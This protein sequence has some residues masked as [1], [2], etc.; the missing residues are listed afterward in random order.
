MPRCD[1]ISH[2][3]HLQQ[4]QELT[5]ARRGVS[6]PSA[7]RGTCAPG[8]A[9]GC[10]RAQR[11]E[12]STNYCS[13]LSRV[14]IAFFGVSIYLGYRRCLRLA[15]Y[16]SQ[17]CS[18]AAWRA[19]DKPALWACRACFK[20]WHAAC[21][22]RKLCNPGPR[23]HGITSPCLETTV[24]R[25]TYPLKRPKLALHRYPIKS[26]THFCRSRAGAATAIHLEKS[27]FARLR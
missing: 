22:T 6:T 12:R 5:L 2:V 20:P 18:Q 14:P 15:H 24:W 11:H 3:L 7:A 25:L 21:A 23:G 10:L 13:D 16:G 17:C 27:I 19:A 9:P 8:L 26:G 4:A 1:R